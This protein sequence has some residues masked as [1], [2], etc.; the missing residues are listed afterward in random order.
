MRSP[1]LRRRRAPMCA[2][3]ALLIVPNLGDMASLSSASRRCRRLFAGESGAVQ[4]RV[5]CAADLWVRRHN[6]EA[7]LAG[8]RGL[9]NSGGPIRAGVSREPSS[10][11]RHKRLSPDL[12][13]PMQSTDSAEPRYMA[14]RRIEIHTGVRPDSGSAK[15]S[16]TVR[17]LQKRRFHRLADG[18]SEAVLLADASG[19]IAAANPAACRLLG[20]TEREICEVGFPGLAGD[21]RSTARVW[22][23][24]PHRRTV[25]QADDSR[26]RRWQHLCRRG[27][28]GR[29]SR[30]R[31]SIVA[32]SP[33]S[34]ATS[35][36]TEP[37]RSSWRS[38]ASA[39]TGCFGSVLQMREAGSSVAT[40]GGR[41][42]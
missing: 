9:R 14:E 30:W 36:P 10:C 3:L 23:R 1:A 39:S 18:D 6:T 8:P 29:G 21:R 41:A 15:S 31:R 42:P 13:L 5:T 17:S 34:C 20:R 25:R 19:D 26:A 4:V 38:L 7:A 33:Q 12:T 24:P 22:R 2:R 32:I 35:T 37:P 27:F 28:R 16:S 11:H 40:G